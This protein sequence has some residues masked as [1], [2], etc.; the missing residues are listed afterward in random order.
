MT[1]T[2]FVIGPIGEP[3]SP[4][5]E[6]ADDL[7]K[8]I[9]MPCAA[10]K[11]FDF[12]LPI[13]ADQLNEPGRITSQ[14]I[15]LLIEADLV[16]ADLTTNNANVYYELSLRHAIGRPVIHTATDGTPLSFDVRDNRTIFYSMHSR[17]AE[18]ARKQLA[19][20]IR[21]VQKDG[22]KATN[23]IV[24]TVGIIKLEHSSDPNQNALGQLMQAVESLRGE[25]QETQKRII[26]ITNAAIA[27]SHSDTGSFNLVDD[28]SFGAVINRHPSKVSVEHPR[29]RHSARTK[30]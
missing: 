7:M 23:P 21:E 13:R 20:Q 28:D 18:V 19:N 16:I 14:V 24:E 9:I 12:G 10:L 6:N 29:R 1:K 25:V 15:K 11:E 30:S 27:A 22:Y 17:A 8:Y 5:R 2:C 26:R 4:V 3:G